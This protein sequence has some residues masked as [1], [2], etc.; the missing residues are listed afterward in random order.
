MRDRLKELVA[1]FKTEWLA[2]DTRPDAATYEPNGVKLWR[3]G[4]P[5][6]TIEAGD[7]FTACDLVG[8]LLTGL[9]YQGDVEE[10]LPDEIEW[11]DMPGASVGYH[12]PTKTKLRVWA[13]GKNWVAYTPDGMVIRTAANRQRYWRERSGA[14]EGCEQMFREYLR[15]KVLATS[16]GNEGAES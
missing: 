4:R 16:V 2:E 11:A 10:D 3:R 6:I 8:A 5:I 13:N 7:P 12:P 1:R 15:A 14:K 9:F